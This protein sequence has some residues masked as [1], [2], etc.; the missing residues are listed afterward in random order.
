M[1]PALSPK[2]QVD[3]FKITEPPGKPILLII[4][5]I[6]VCKYLSSTYNVPGTALDAGD[7]AVSKT[8]PLASQT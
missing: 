8:K 1:S 3:I 2:L 5:S 4:M 7:T 6:Q